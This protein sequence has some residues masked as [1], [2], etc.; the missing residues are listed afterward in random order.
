MS[1][2]IIS[3]ILSLSALIVNAQE[4]KSLIVRND[5]VT[6]ELKEVIVTASP[7]V[8]TASKVILYPTQQERRY[9][10]NAYQ[11][12]E[13][14][15]IP[16]LVASNHNKSISVLNGQSVQCLI[17][18]IEA[19][20][21]EIATL[22]A[23]NVLSIEFQR[24]PGGKYVGK[25]GV[26]NFITRQYDYGGNLYISADEGFAYQYGDYLSFANHKK[27]A[28]T[29]SVIS[30]FKW[31]TEHNQSFSN[32]TYNL[33]SGRL[34]QAV[35]PLSSTQ[36]SRDTYGRF[37]ID[38]TQE[39]H[40]FNASLYLKSNEI[41]TDS[42]RSLI[43]YS[44]LLNKQTLSSRYSSSHAWSPQL[45]ADYTLYI[46]DNQYLNLTSSISYGRNKYTG[47]WQE[48]GFSDIAI[49][50]KE[51]NQSYN[52]SATYNY[53]LQNNCSLGIN[54]DHTSQIYSDLYRG[55][56]N[57][58]QN[59]TTRFSTA[60]MQW[61]QTLSPL[62]IFYYISAGYSLANS[63]INGR[64]D[65]YWNPVIYYGGN[66]AI[67]QNQAV[68]VNGNYLH[69]I[70]SPEYKNS[71]ILPTSFFQT[72]V[73]NPELNVLKAF[74]NYLTYSVTFN[75]LKIS[76]SYDFMIYFDNIVNKYYEKD[77]ILYKTL[78]NDG[79]FYSNRIILSATYCMFN[80]RLRFNGNSITELFN[81]KGNEYI[82]QHQGIRGSL[83]LAYYIGRWSIRTSYT[84]PYNTFSMREP[85]YIRN[86]CQYGIV[87]TW[88][89]D[90]LQIEAGTDNFINKYLNDKRYFDYKSWE[91]NSIDKLSNKGRNIY[92]SV[93]YTLPYGKKTDSPDISY[94]STINNAILKPF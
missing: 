17:N 21:D 67:N 31:N 7:L 5:S 10:T 70:I 91:M 42:I 68:S 20:P 88:N 60:L 54:I 71:L 6:S 32:N 30:S 4:N 41:P 8:E 12:I 56:S 63:N 1:H 40:S 27:N 51:N 9:S 61:Q 72:T 75:T 74:Q 46:C 69:T 50:S 90:N 44:G 33:Y 14:M 76:A 94:K 82:C 80:N 83:S 53:T 64:R 48:T 52:A 34:Y 19:Q 2:K 36:N 13:N 24:T 55:W 25:G 92:V 87:V 29:L 73:G 3:L 65:N 49:E 81:L 89:N 47:I 35:N 85:A 23:K 28:L 93:T 62:N 15:N 39:N 37:K 59:L 79:N 18:G 43:S 11:L 77:N 84:T 38:H 16:N 26:I 66:F 78:I 86:N 22:S 58:R 57:S 45:D